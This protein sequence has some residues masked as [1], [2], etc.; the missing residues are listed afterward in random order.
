[1]PNRPRISLLVTTLGALGALL[2]VA[3]GGSEGAEVT[4]MSN[5]AATAAARETQATETAEPTPEVTWPALGTARVIT[6][7]LNVRT[8]PGPDYLVLGRLQPGDE[9]P[10]SGRAA[11]GRWLALPGI[12]W[13]AH[14]PTWVEVD[15]DLEEMPLIP[16]EEA[17]YEFVSPLHPLDVVVDIPVVDQ[18]V[19][20]VALADRTALLALSATAG[21]AS[22]GDDASDQAGDV[23]APPG[24]AC[25]DD[26]YP[27]A[28][29]GDRLDAFLASSAGAEGPLH[30]YAVVG[31]PAGED[32]DAQPEFSAVFAFEGGEGRQVWIDPTGQGILW[33][34]L[35]CDGMAPGD[36]LR[37]DRGELF[38][39]F[40]PLVPPPLDPVE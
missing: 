20:A 40:R 8:G 32:D 33:F 35:G 12:G 23:G 13:M 34:S 19:E 18:V 21:E 3:C 31:A 38:F 28:E 26:V 16:L 2:I 6:E 4:A 39:W 1:V 5:A 10:V 24:H 22:E 11:S 25:S 15:V 36:L 30:L 9:V 14:D 17:G 37:L 27:G 29:L 7:D